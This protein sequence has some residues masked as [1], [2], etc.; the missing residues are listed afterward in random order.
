MLEILYGIFNNQDLFEIAA[1]FGC[2][3]SVVLLVLFLL[4]SNRDERGLKILGKASIIS[5]VFFIVLVNSLAGITMNM[6]AKGFLFTFNVY[7]H[8]VQLIYNLVIFCEISAILIL[9]KI[10]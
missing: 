4:K 3:V 5:F 9:R 2:I 7:G 10:Q 1:Y 8:I 6:E